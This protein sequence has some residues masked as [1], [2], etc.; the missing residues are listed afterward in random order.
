VSH[1]IDGIISQARLVSRVAMSILPRPNSV[2]FMTKRP[3]PWWLRALHFLVA[4]GLYDTFAPGLVTRLV[5]PRASCLVQCL[6]LMPPVKWA[7]KGNSSDFR[8]Y[9]MYQGGI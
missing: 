6:P 5:V 8:C 2:P 3:D 7:A 9:L 4:G 1:R